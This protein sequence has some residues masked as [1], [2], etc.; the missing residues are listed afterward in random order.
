MQHS[1]RWTKFNRI[2]FYFTGKFDQMFRIIDTLVNIKFAKLIECFYHRSN[3]NDFKVFMYWQLRVKW[4]LT[5]FRIRRTE[6]TIIRGI[7]NEKYDFW[8][9]LRKMFTNRKESPI[10][11]IKNNG[12]QLLWMCLMNKKK[13]VSLQA[14]CAMF[15]S[16]GYENKK[17]WSRPR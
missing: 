2:L 7:L 8:F 16:W 10:H 12:L 5:Y 14:F 6:N 17:I 11:W 13:K 1:I 9:S 4:N 3:S 15:R